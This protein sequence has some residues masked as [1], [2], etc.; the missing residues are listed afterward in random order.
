MVATIGGANAALTDSLLSYWNHNTTSVVDI[1]GSFT[2]ASSSGLSSVTGKIGNAN[3]FSAQTSNA[4]FASTFNQSVSFSFCGWYMPSGNSG[5][6]PTIFGRRNVFSTTWYTY[7][8]GVLDNGTAFFQTEGNGANSQATL[9][10]S[11]GFDTNGTWRHLCVTYNNSTTTG[12]KLIYINGSVVGNGSYSAGLYYGGSHTPVMGYQTTGV[13]AYNATYDEM[14]FWT[15]VLTAEEISSLYN[16]GSGC[17]YPFTVCAPSTELQIVAYDAYSNTTITSFNATVEWNGSL[18]NY[19]T[20]NGTIITTSMVNSTFPANVTV[21]AFHYFENTTTGVTSSSLNASMVPYVFS[22]SSV[23]RSAAIPIFGVEN[24]TAIWFSDEP[25]STSVVF[26]FTCNAE[27]GSPSWT[28]SVSNDS[29]VQCPVSGA[30]FAYEVTLSSSN[31]TSTPRVFNLT[32]DFV[33]GPFTITAA[34]ASNSSLL[35]TFNATV[36]GDF[37]STVTGIL[38]ASNVSRGDLVN[39]TVEAQYYDSYV[40]DSYNSSSNL[41]ALLERTLPPAAANV[42]VV[43]SFEWLFVEWDNPDPSLVSSF[44]LYLNGSLNGSTTGGEW[45]FSGLST[46]SPWLVTIEAVTLVGGATNYSFFANTTF[47]PPPV[48]TRVFPPAALYNASENSTATFSVDVE[49]DNGWDVFVEW[50][51]NGVSTF[52]E[53]VTGGSGTSE[54]EIDLNYTSS[55][56]YNV[57][58]VGTDSL[59]T[60][61]SESVV[62]WTV[63]VEDTY[64]VPAAPVAIRPSPGPFEYELPLFCVTRGAEVQ[65]AYYD[66]LVSID[67][68][69]YAPFDPSTRDGLK[70]FD[71]AIHPYGTN[72]SFACRVRSPA[73]EGNYTYSGNYTRGDTNH[74]TLLSSGVE[75]SRKAFQPYS[76]SFRIEAA[77][78]IGATIYSAFVDCNGDGVWDYVYDYDGEERVDAFETFQCLNPSGAFET[79]VGFALTKNNSLSWDGLGCRGVRAADPFCAVYKRYEVVVE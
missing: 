77:N 3:N 6:S 50:F 70:L 46:G 60:T 10:S 52:W 40:N 65:P 5:S 48:L 18:T 22:S 53:W 74:F 72:A 41:A 78:N 23:F 24:F 68:S 8:I 57:S 13:T 67:G 61:G 55:G 42:S 37:Y 47:N 31:N 34:D 76:L 7:R 28:G 19:T 39:V 4:S 69:A 51:V 75:A 29:L 12:N 64:P 17:T 16:S 49:S 71:F 14:A 79:L 63:T 38:E 73:G 21:H 32:V 36:D 1:A 26:N 11:G 44:N 33:L 43:E 35:Q 45:N 2:A 9:S 54:F 27:A 20:T 62:E 66:W 30:S 15:R 58:A 25:P 59:N 56:E